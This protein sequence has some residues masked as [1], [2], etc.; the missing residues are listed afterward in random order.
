[1]DDGTCRSAQTCTCRALGSTGRPVRWG[2]WET[3]RPVPS[4]RR[5]F[6]RPGGGCTC[7]IRRTCTGPSGGSLDNPARPA[8]G[9]RPA[10]PSAVRTVKPSSKDLLAPCLLRLLA[11]LRRYNQW[12]RTASSVFGLLCVSNSKSLGVLSACRRKKTLN[13]KDTDPLVNISNETKVRAL[14]ALY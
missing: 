13:L 11:A 8:V 9:G 2:G 5:R 12:A 6:G 3:H 7:R 10:G 1:M 14:F 4:Y